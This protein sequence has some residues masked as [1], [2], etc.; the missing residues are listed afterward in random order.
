MNRNLS[1]TLFAATLAL[2]L[3][4]AGIA[5]P[6]EDQLSQYASAAKAAD[7]KFAGFSAE[8]G[9]TLHTQAFGGGKPDRAPPLCKPQPRMIRPPAGSVNSTASPAMISAST[10]GRW[11]LP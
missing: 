11:L 9:K 2:S 6:R 4:G 8:R 5:G 10:C 1:T 7:P 3:S